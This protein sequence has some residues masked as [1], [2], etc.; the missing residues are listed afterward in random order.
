MCDISV[1][2]NPSAT[3]SPVSRTCYVCVPCPCLCSWTS[4]ARGIYSVSCPMLDWSGGCQSG[5]DVPSYPSL[6]PCPSPCP[7]LFLCPAL[8]PSLFLCLSPF[9][10]LALSLVPSPSLALFRAPSPSLPPLCAFSPFP[11]SPVP[12]LLVLF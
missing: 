1:T 2:I 5:F 9:H 10:A 4:G 12:A 8:S 6:C 11:P 7:S 3:L